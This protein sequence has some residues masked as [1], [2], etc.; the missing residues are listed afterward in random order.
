MRD[1]SI[2]LFFPI[3]LIFI[4]HIFQYGRLSSLWLWLS[5]SNINRDGGKTHVPWEIYFYIYIILCVVYSNIIYTFNVIGLMGF[6]FLRHHKLIDSKYWL[7]IYGLVFLWIICFFF[8]NNWCIAIIILNVWWTKC[9]KFNIEILV[10]I[11]PI[12]WY[13]SFE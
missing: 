9:I 7:S 4:F 5:S 13:R 8:K 10:L 6:F 2:I 1:L 12:S 3:L 11:K